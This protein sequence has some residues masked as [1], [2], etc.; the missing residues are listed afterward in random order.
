MPLFYSASIKLDYG[1]MLAS[2]D[3]CSFGSFQYLYVFD[4]FAQDKRS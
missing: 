1:G 2:D 3:G 4:F